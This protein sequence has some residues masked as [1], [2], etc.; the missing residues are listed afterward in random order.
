MERIFTNALKKQLKQRIKG[1]LS[2]HIVDDTLIVD[3]QS[4]GYY[5]WQYTINNL[6]VQISSRI[7]ADD[8][9]KQYKKYILSKY[10]YSK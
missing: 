1:D 7:V 3:I 6:A 2:V 8:I 4:V 10:F 9:V 5:T